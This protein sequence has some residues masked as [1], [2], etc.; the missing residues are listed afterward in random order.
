MPRNAFGE[1]GTFEMLPG[2]CIMSWDEESNGR[3][4]SLAMRIVVIS[5]IDWLFWSKKARWMFMPGCLFRIIIHLLC[6]TRNRPLSSSMRKI[7][8]GYVVNLNRRHC[9]YGHLF[10]NRYKSIVWPV[11]SL[12][13]KS[14]MLTILSQIYEHQ[15][16]YSDLRFTHSEFMRYLARACL[17]K[18]PSTPP[19]ALHNMR[20][21][22]EERYFLMMWLVDRVTGL[23]G[24]AFKEVLTGGKQRRTVWASSV[25]A[26]AGR[27]HPGGARSGYRRIRTS[28]PRRPANPWQWADK[29]CI[30][31]FCWHPGR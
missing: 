22:I 10:Q 30:V 31:I 18:Q 20:G 13:V 2:F 25:Y 3:R 11:L 4:Y 15:G 16:R 29:C 23:S 6:R 9:R 1:G 26:I 14:L 21:F 17:E 28:R 7:L 24:L 5:S 8:T 19:G 27:G 12:P